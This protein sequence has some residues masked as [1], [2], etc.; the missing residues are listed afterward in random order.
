MSYLISK[1]IPKIIIGDPI[2]LR[3][4]LL[5]LASNSIKFTEKGRVKIDIQLK[6]KNED[7]YTLLFNINDTGIGIPDDKLLSIFE[8]FTQASNETTRKFGGTGLGLTI[9]KQLVELQGGWI[10]VNSEIGKGSCFS[11]TLTFR[12]GD[13]GDIQIK[14]DETTISYSEL[15]DI[16]IL[17]AED[18]IMN[19]LLAR[20]IF[21]KWNCKFDIA[22]NGKIAVDKLLQTDY[23]IILMD[24]QM[25]EMDG[26]EAA[27]YIR[28]NLPSPKSKI[29][30]IAL[31]AHALVGEK[32]KCLALGM[33]DY[34][35]KPFNQRVLYEKIK[36][37]TVKK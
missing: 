11:F 22:D 37:L 17:L 23:D 33:N 1:D 20:K 7:R 18:N 28:T 25:P 19:Q 13:P 6:N 15:Q 12:K 30:I 29:P 21:K 3:Q 34:I 5:N 10:S 4:I 32:E 9:T 35:S 36:E 2:R 16:Y 14:P 31:T 24:M 27:N 26:Y 8:S